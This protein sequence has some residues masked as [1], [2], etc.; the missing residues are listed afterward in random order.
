MH[1][2]NSH[3]GPEGI[4]LKPHEQILGLPHPEGLMV[5]KAYRSDSVGALDRPR[6][7]GRSRWASTVFHLN[8]S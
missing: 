5:P 8:E 6:V 2:R 3:V 1:Q 4:L 7:A